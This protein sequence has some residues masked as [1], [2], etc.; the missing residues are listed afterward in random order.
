MNQNFLYVLVA[1]LAASAIGFGYLYYQERQTGIA[2]KIDES[3][4]TID[5]K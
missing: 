2:I 3:G 5:G 1:V 4:V